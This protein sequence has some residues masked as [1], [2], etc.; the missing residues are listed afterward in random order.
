M[1]PRL[2]NP[3]RIPLDFLQR[4][5]GE[6]MFVSE[7][8]LVTAMVTV[9]ALL[10]YFWAGFNVGR[11][12]GKHGISAPAMTGQPEFERAVRVHMN[13][14]EWLVILLPLLWMATIYFSPS[15]TMAWLSWL[16]PVF[17]LIWI[18]GRIL[19]MTGYMAAAEKRSLGFS[20]SGLAVVGLLIM[21]IAGIVMQWNAVTAA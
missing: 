16:P 3:P 17:G 20:I 10:F 7:I 5:L 18:L 8:S 4:H 13:T 15:M 12:R 11:L 19:Y 14:L 6:A 9:L 2:P 1:R 21:T